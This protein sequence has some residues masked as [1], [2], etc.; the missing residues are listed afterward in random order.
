MP[1]TPTLHQTLNSPPPSASCRLSEP[2]AG[3]TSTSTPLIKPY[4]GLTNKS[5]PLTKQY[6]GLACTS[7]PPT[8]IISTAPILIGSSAPSPSPTPAPHHPPKP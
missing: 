1:N 2:Y 7:L 8:I 4:A 6:A 5:T 3:L